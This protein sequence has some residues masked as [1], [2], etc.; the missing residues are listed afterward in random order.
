MNNLKNVA[1]SATRMKDYTVQKANVD[2]LKLLIFS[3]D[4][5]PEA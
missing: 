4:C 1:E 5:Q 3:A 2:G